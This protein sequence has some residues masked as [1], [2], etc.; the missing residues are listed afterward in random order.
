MSGNPNDPQ[1]K[2]DQ[3]LE[4]Y[5]K[6]M[7]ARPP[8]EDVES[9]GDGGV[10]IPPVENRLLAQD[11]TVSEMRHTV[12]AH[13]APVES[14]RTW[15]ERGERVHID[16]PGG[17]H[18]D[19]F[20]RTM[21][22]GPWM[23]LLHGFPTSSWD[24]APVSE[25]LARDHSLLLLDLLGFG[26]S[27]KPKGHDWSAFEQADIVEALW[28]RNG[29]E[30]TRLVAHDVGLTVALELLARQE[31]GT[32]RTVIS[33][34]TLLNGGIY[35]GF[36]RPRRIQVLLQKPVLGFLIARMLNESRFA[37]ALAEVFAPTHQPSAAELHQHWE[38]VARR[39][40]S[41]NYHRL[42]RYIPERR[43]HAPR[44][45]GAVEK[46]ATPIRFIWGMADP[47][48]GTQMAEQVK[49]RRPGADLVELA[50]VGHYPQLEAPERVAAEI[51]RPVPGRPSMPRQGGMV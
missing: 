23:T 16:L 24:W 10:E 41:K 33:D 45:E 39:D 17:A 42:I 31:E 3:L 36:H 9:P 11:P 46:T 4:G 43:Q 37:P 14:L 7:K 8:V 12:E 18:W 34:L 5:E 40:G 32:L 27:D 44:W 30:Q 38:S 51:L 29:V 26:D 15:W 48:S 2:L 6:D 20:T 19:I 35:T 25:R 22:G 28:R 13:L 49:K 50:D 1:A 21:G 47:V